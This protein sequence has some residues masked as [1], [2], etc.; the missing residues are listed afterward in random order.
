MHITPCRP[1]RSPPRTA[2]F[3]ALI[4]SKRLTARSVPGCLPPA[5]G[6]PG[7]RAGE[8]ASRAALTISP[9]PGPPPESGG[10]P[11]AAPHAGVCVRPDSCFQHSVGRKHKGAGSRAFP[12]TGAGRGLGLAAAHPLRSRAAGGPARASSTNCQ[13]P[14][15]CPRA[16]AGLTGTC[17]SVCQVPPP[18]CLP[19]VTRQF[20]MFTI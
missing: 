10:A 12:L 8:G 6:R 17:G 13:W 15:R 11:R 7:A 4:F 2:T 5:G 18:H 14:R 19:C 9:R 1:G 3:Y 16:A 20:T